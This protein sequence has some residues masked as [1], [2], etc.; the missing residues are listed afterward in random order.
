[1]NVLESGVVLHGAAADSF[2]PPITAEALHA[3]LA[4]EVRYLR[5]EIVDKPD[6]EWRDVP[7][8]RVYA[9]LTLCRV[10]YSHTYGTVVSKPKAAEWAFSALPHRWHA[11]IAGALAADAGGSAHSLDL[12]TIA[13][14]IEFTEAR[15]Q[16]T[17][18]LAATP[19]T[20]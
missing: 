6:S 3:A 8:Y 19:A 14:F 18:N 2:V 20:S 11:V 10:L 15:L 17:G 4:R 7:K 1:M 5:E 12:S 9:V 13:L 16:V